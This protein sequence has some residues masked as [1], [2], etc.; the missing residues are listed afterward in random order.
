MPNFTFATSTS[1]VAAKHPL[2]F[3]TIS[4]TG[5]TGIIPV[6]IT[7]DSLSALQ[8]VA[9][10]LQP[11]A[12]TGYIGL[13]GPS[14]DYL[15]VLDWGTNASP[16]KGLIANMDRAATTAPFDRPF[17]SGPSS[18]GASG[19]NAIPFSTAMFL[20]GS[21]TAQGHFPVA[22]TAHMTLK[23]AIPSSESDVGLRQWSLFLR[24]DQ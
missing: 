5:G 12:G 11:F 3:G 18:T 8:N 2:S 20:A 15:D 10:Y 23:L 14:Q 9:V 16:Q 17:R 13:Y 7:H 4:N 21:S 22:N 6:H 24:F 1:M 19:T